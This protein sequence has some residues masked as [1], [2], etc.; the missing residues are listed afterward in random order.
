[1]TILDDLFKEANRPWINIHGTTDSTQLVKVDSAMVSIPG[2]NLKESLDQ[3]FVPP[4]D[5]LIYNPPITLK[6]PASFV[7]S[8]L[9]IATPNFGTFPVQRNYLVQWGGGPL[10]PSAAFVQHP[11]GPGEV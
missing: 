3:P 9:T 8:S 7:G 4:I 6:S 11:V 2:S 10:V 5:R 1:M